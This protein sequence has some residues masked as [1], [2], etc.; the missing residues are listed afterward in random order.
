MG[1]KSPPTNSVDPKWHRISGVMGYQ[2][3]GLRGFRLYY[4]R[5]MWHNATCCCVA[6]YLLVF[7]AWGPGQDTDPQT[8]L[9]RFVK[10]LTSRGKSN[11]NLKSFSTMFALF[12]FSQTLGVFSSAPGVWKAGFPV[13]TQ[14]RDFAW[15]FS[16]E[17]PRDIQL[18]V[19]DYFHAAAWT[20]QL[21]FLHIVQCQLPN[22]ALVI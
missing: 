10:W 4:S 12:S 8:N 7:S 6:V 11:W 9:T 13:E 22:S 5:A 21:T 3:H 19:D 1:C 15:R 16:L 20:H 2:K 14:S 18:L 17:K